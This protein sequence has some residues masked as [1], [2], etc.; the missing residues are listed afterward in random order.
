MFKQTKRKGGAE[1][2]WIRKK[3]GLLAEQCKKLTDMFSS[4][5]T[6]SDVRM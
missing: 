1:K 4:P 5:A 3:S 2:E 6:S